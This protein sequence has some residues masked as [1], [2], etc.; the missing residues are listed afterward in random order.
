MCKPVVVDILLWPDAMSGKHS[1]ICFDD[2]AE[3]QR[4]ANT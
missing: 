3:R 4:L 1:F 2:P